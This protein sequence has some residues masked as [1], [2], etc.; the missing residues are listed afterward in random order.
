MLKIAY[1]SVLIQNSFGKGPCA[2]KALGSP[3]GSSVAL[4]GRSPPALITL[5]PGSGYLGFPLTIESLLIDIILYLLWKEVFY[6]LSL[7]NHLPYS[8]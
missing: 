4:K 7:F 2:A 8:G 1:R 3:F 6:G 5:D